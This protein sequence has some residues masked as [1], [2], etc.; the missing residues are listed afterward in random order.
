[1]AP[2]IMITID[3]ATYASSDVVH[4]MNNLMKQLSTSAPALTTADV[5]RILDSDATT[6]LLASE[7]GAVVGML[8]LVVVAIPTGMRALIED[9]VV[10]EAARGHGVGELLTR[11]AIDHARRHGATTV[12]LTSRPA[13][14]AANRLYQ[15]VGFELRETNVYRFLAETESK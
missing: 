13:R 2:L 5:Q 6:L 9:V 14:E 1:M 3:T 12:D 15:R 11:T 10:D 8:T 4:A 7:D